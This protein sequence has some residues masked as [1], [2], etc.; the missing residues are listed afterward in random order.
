MSQMRQ[1]SI[2]NPPSIAPFPKHNKKTLRDPTDGA[3]LY[4]R[5]Y[6]ICTKPNWQQQFWIQCQH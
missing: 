2:R 3:G 5:Y 4:K 6:F 1:A